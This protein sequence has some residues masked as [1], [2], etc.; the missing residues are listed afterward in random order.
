[1]H[2]VRLLGEPCVRMVVGK[3]YKQSSDLP[4]DQG[5]DFKSESA[6]IYILVSWTV[7]SFYSYY[8]HSCTYSIVVYQPRGGVSLKYGGKILDNVPNK[9]DI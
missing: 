2:L 6:A 1:M 3:H 4:G 5:L 8:T 9:L 7:N